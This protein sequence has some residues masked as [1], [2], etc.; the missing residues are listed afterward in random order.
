[1]RPF[2]MEHS[3]VAH[4][5]H[6]WKKGKYWEEGNDDNDVSQGDLHNIIFKDHNEK[7]NKSYDDWI[8]FI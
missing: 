3:S 1:M 4:Q 5:L 2:I 7:E 8:R 6:Q